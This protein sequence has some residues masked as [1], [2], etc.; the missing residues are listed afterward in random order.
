M[1]LILRY[2][3]LRVVEVCRIFDWYYLRLII[4]P[5]FT[6]PIITVLSLICYT[7]I[8]LGYNEN[9]A[10]LIL[11]IYISL[12]FLKKDFFRIFIF[13]L[14]SAILVFPSSYFLEKRVKFQRSISEK[15][16]LYDG[17]DIKVEVRVGNMVKQRAGYQTLW[18]KSLSETNI[19]I[20]APR[21][22]DIAKGSFCTV[23]GR[24]SFASDLDDFGKYLIVNN[25]YVYIKANNLD[26]SPPE[27][28]SI[29]SI[30]RLKDIVVRNIERNISEPNASLLIGIMFGDDRVYTEDFQS[31][32]R[33]TGLTHIV[34]A[35]GYNISFVSS[36]FQSS[37]FFLT[38]K[39]R[40]IFT[41]IGVYIYVFIAGGSASVVRA[42]GSYFLGF[43]SSVY[44]RPLIPISS[45]FFLAMIMLLINPLYIFDIGFKLSFLATLAIVFYVPV[46]ISKLKLPESF[47]IPL[48]CS[49]MVL[50]V[51]SAS[52]GESSIV[53]TVTNFLALG[54]LEYLMISGV[55]FSIFAI[56][57]PSSL[58]IASIIVESQ[59]VILTYVVD[60]FSRF[61]FAT[62]DIS[63]ELSVILVFVVTSVIL[64]HIKQNGSKLL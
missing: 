18:A 27:E 62:I 40:N 45:L 38:Y 44:G 52:F 29:Y 60:I 15:L 26:C 36:L 43:I 13:L 5:L 58:E 8:V 37:F 19:Y 24:L 42:F 31:R 59:F 39:P 41:S 47:A 51:L 11:S 12:F 14:I 34:A 46:V 17:K 20:Q 25:S 28:D 2:I 50:P 16:I 30:Y 23:L 3:Y 33:V 4:N 6:I 49:I 56:I 10:L 63:L 7:N 35:S 22:P 21:Y 48:M 53:S 32:V 54:S 55:V 61:K 57:L 9:T 64:V 1:S